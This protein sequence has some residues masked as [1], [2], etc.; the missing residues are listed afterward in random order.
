MLSYWCILTFELIFIDYDII[1]PAQRGT[2]KL[3]NGKKYSRI[4][5][6]TKWTEIK[7]EIFLRSGKSTSTKRFFPLTLRFAACVCMRVF[8]SCVFMW[9]QKIPFNVKTWKIR[10]WIYYYTKIFVIFEMKKG[11]MKTRDIIFISFYFLQSFNE[12]NQ[13]N[14]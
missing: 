10:K 1:Q 8:E 14:W 5:L 6:S 9:Y 4:P 12:G 11:G 2:K 13:Q 7:E 3:F